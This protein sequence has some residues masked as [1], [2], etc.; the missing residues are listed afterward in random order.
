MV[1]SMSRRQLASSH[2][3]LQGIR[4]LT[5]EDEPILSIALEEML[6]DL[7]CRVVA[8]ASTLTQALELGTHTAFD[9]AVL[10]ISLADEKVDQAAHVIVAR[11]IPVV[12]TT[13]HSLSDAGAGLG[14]ASVIEKPYTSDTLQKALLT[15]LTL[16]A[17]TDV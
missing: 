7:G 9:I 10:D 14:A 1:G 5:A 4:V 11:G 16:T 13:G 15:A 6:D 17:L 8:S 3:Q 2:D 12:L